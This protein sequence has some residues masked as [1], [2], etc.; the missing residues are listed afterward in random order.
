[1]ADFDAFASGQ[2]V[3]E[4]PAAEFLAREQSELAGLEDFESGDAGQTQGSTGMVVFLMYFDLPASHPRSRSSATPTSPAYSR[5]SC[6]LLVS[7]V[8]Q[9]VKQRFIEK[10]LKYRNIMKMHV[11]RFMEVTKQTGQSQSQ[12]LE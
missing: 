3:E 7:V 12:R 8:C 2:E 5:L 11:L 10:R 4:D 9:N 6:L 1:M